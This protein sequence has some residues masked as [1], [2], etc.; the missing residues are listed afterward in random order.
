MIVV[1][2]L[3]FLKGLGGIVVVMQGVDAGRVDSPGHCL[4]RPALS[5]ASRKEGEE[6]LVFT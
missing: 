5:T 3:E 6:G 4:A 1:K 2:G